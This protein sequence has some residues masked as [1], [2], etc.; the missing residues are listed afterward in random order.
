MKLKGQL[1]V[2]LSLAIGFNVGCEGRPVDSPKLRQG[3]SMGTDQDERIRFPAVAGLFYQRDP[4]G[5]RSEIDRFLVAADPGAV[6]GLRAIV[7]PHAGYS[8]S[9][10]TAAFGYKLLVGRDVD[11]VIVLAPSHYAA[12]NGASIPDVD[13]YRTP[14]GDVRLSGKVVELRK[15]PPFVEN[16][17][18]QVSRPTWWRQASKKLPDFGQDTPHSW[19]HSLE[20]QLPFLQQ[21][22]NKFTIIPIVLGHVESDRVADVLLPLLDDKTLVVVSSD[23]SHY[24]PYDEAVSLDKDCTNA[25]C[26]LDVE[27][28][29]RQEACGKG[30]LL[31]LMRIAKKK[32]WRAKL[33]D[34]R[35]SGDTSGD[36]S[37]VV[38]YASIAFFDSVEQDDPPADYT[39]KAQELMLKLAR[40]SVAEFVTNGRLPD[41]SQ[42][43]LTESL[44]QERACFVTL[45]KNG[46]L[47]G[48]I[49]SI[50]PREPLWQAI[51]HMARDAATKDPRFVRVKSAELDEIHIEISVLTIPKQFEFGSTQK[52][53]DR[54]RPEIDGVV[55][56]V[57]HRQ[58]TFLPQVWKQLPDKREFLIRLAM[59]AGLAG[60]AWEDP[61]AQVLLYQAEAFQEQEK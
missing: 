30:A 2:L 55:L 51:L 13:A 28:M 32:G 43:E 8:F 52:L 9:G 49:G 59:K 5:L 46:Q 42:S 38:G 6:K 21:T 48:C 29:S 31:T 18:S 17:P 15:Q 53:L 61:E 50:F 44:Q 58:A 36:K 4:E 22:L 3:I 19:E 45:K 12:F 24:C 27:S 60:D 35:N 39:P 16:P 40:A 14:L 11:T 1:L 54:L 34:Y 56:K 41:V 25:I 33:I 10:Q 57:G 7:S 26:A 37:H 47:R 23:L 20:V